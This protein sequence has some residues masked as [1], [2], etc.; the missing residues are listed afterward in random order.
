MEPAIKHED[1]MEQYEYR[2][3][4]NSQFEDENF[5]NQRK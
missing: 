2:E 5:K 1:N 4:K 3:L